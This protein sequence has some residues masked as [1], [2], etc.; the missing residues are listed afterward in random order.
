MGRDL[1]APECKGT[2]ESESVAARVL[3]VTDVSVHGSVMRAAFEDRLGINVIGPVTA[4]MCTPSHIERLRPS[5][6]LVDASSVSVEELAVSFATVSLRLPVVAYALAKGD[7]TRIGSFFDLGAKGF[8]DRDAGLEELERTLRAA[9]DGEI[10]CSPEVLTSLVMTFGREVRFASRGQAFSKLT[11]REAE[12][13]VLYISGLS[14]KEVGGCLGITSGTVEQHLDHIYKK[15]GI[16][17]R[18]EMARIFDARE[19]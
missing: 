17:G 8:V 2:S 13:A 9:L 1:P 18:T 6:L 7:Q 16:H 5:I 10:R 3:L 4:S 11:G 19:I 12:V 15:L 14:A